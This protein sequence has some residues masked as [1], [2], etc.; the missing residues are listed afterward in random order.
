M[1]A[2]LELETELRQGCIIPQGRF[3][4]KRLTNTVDRT[5]SGKS[6]NERSQHYRVRW[7]PSLGQDRG[8]IKSGSRYPQGVWC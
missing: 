7:T 5:V 3:A 4:Q 1:T 6:W 8:N 2:V